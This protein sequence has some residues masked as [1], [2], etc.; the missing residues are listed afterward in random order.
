MWAA[1]PAGNCTHGLP[2]APAAPVRYPGGVVMARWEARSACQ[3]ADP[4][5]FFP[6]AEDQVS[7]DRAKAICDRCP[8]QDECLADALE[9]RA[10]HGRWGIRGGFSEAERRYLHK[11]RLRRVA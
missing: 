2:D 3:G 8:V 9:N 6:A 11:S 7:I 5:L 1:G 4:D 10:G